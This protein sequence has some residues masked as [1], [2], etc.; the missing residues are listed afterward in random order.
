MS[1]EVAV[2]AVVPL[3]D[4]A[5]QQAEVHDEVMAELAVV[6]EAAAFIGGAAVTEFETA[7]AEFSGAQH[8]VGVANGTDALELALRAGG[9]RAGGEVILPANTFIATAEAVSRIGA[10]PIPVDVDPQYLLMDPAAVAAAVTERT[11]AIVPVH[12]FGQSA[13]VEQLLPIAEAC[14]AVI[15]EDAAQSQGATRLGRPAGTWGVAAGTSFYPGK[16][17]GAAGDAGGV[18]TNDPDVAAQ[19]RMLGAHGSSVKYRHDAVGINSRLDTV[20]AVVL[21]AKLARLQHWNQLRRDAAARYG[22][23]LAGVAGVELPVQAPGNEDVWHLYVVR[24]D[25]RDAVLAELQAEGI[26]AGIHYPIPVHLSGAYEG[27]GWAAGSFPVTEH[28]AGRILS[29]PIFPHI[30]VAQQERVAEVLIKAMNRR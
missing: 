1:V 2:H 4:L 9:V 7:Y 15:I 24:V 11:Q 16:N 13:F 3:V 22:E 26:H 6:F 10:I 20:Q 23:L 19:V 25:D 18:L 27:D 28:A 5:A 12:L 30:T 14:G 17:L 21:K 29:L 8:C